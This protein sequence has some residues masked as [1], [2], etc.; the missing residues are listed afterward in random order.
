MPYTQCALLVCSFWAGAL[1]GGRLELLDDEAVR[2]LTVRILLGS[3]PASHSGSASQRERVLHVEVT[4]ETEP[5]FLFTLD[6]GEDDFHE[7]KRDQVRRMELK[8]TWEEGGAG[9]QWRHCPSLT[10]P[11][12]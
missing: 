1:A 8:R 9:A 6:V 4:D 5:F 7:L 12:C 11:F 10:S 3:R 2:E